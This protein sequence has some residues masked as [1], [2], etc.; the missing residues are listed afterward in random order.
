MSPLLLPQ[1]DLL[2]RTPDDL[3]LFEQLEQLYRQ[4]GRLADADK[5]RSRAEALAAL[6][7]KAN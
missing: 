4:Q 1:L 3:A 2:Q 7:V 5:M 6:L